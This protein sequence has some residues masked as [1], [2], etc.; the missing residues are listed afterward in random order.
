MV[1]VLK[2]IEATGAKVGTTIMIEGEP[3]TVRKTD[4]SK[5]GKHG[6]AKCRIEAVHVF[7]GNKKVFVSPGHDKF[8]VPVL[9]KRK[10]QVLSIAEDKASLMDLESFETIEIA[11]PDELKGQLEENSN[12]EYWQ[13]GEQMMIKRKV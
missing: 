5:T 3:Y 8:E 1:E 11:I 13:I 7:N 9:N 6:H 12:V 2:I 4:T 10:G